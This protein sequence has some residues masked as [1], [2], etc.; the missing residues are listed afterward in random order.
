MRLVK[1]NHTL[2]KIAY[3]CILLHIDFCEKPELNCYMA[4]DHVRDNFYYVYLLQSLKSS[5]WYTGY[6][7]NL[8][9]RF[10][11]HQNN[12]STYTNGRGP[13]RL[14]Y[15]EACLAEDD[16][17][18]RERYLK[19]G[20]GRRYLRN[21]MKRFL[22]LTWWR[23]FLMSIRRL[24]PFAKRTVKSTSYGK[25]IQCKPSCFYFE[26]PPF[27]CQKIYKRRSFKSNKS[28]RKYPGKRK[29]SPN[30]FPR[31]YSPAGCILPIPF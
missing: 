5:K 26:G 4:M 18:A 3:Y 31:F 28:R 27:N 16:A 20:M 12:E 23:I 9:N 25:S 10:K 1:N 24:L 14:I 15:Y 22:S 17:R 6:T 29:C 21:R 2:H 19:S 30:I 8:R 7:K 11:E 13:F